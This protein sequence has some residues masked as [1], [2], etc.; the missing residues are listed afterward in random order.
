[1]VGDDGHDLADDAGL[2]DVPH[3]DVPHYDVPH[4]VVVRRNRLH[5]AWT[6]SSAWSQC[7]SAATRL[8]EPE[9]W[10]AGQ[11]EMPSSSRRVRQPSSGVRHG[12]LRPQ[13]GRSGRPGPSLPDAHV[14]R[15]MSAI[16]GSANDD[17]SRMLVGTFRLCR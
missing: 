14:P 3:Y 9:D 16:D 6:V 2:D 12:R 7:S 4:H 11:S 5:M 15:N 8:E 1:M 17:I 13:W 10:A